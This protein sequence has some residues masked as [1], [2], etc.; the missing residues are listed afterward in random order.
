MINA[1]ATGRNR[2][3]PPELE[4]S[5]GAQALYDGADLGDARRSKR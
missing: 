1:S 3:N 5:S 2:A 4:A